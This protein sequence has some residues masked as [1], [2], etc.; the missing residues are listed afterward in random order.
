CHAAEQSMRQ[1]NVSIRE[2]E[3]VINTVLSNLNGVTAALVQS[4]ELLKNES[5]GIKSEVGEALV[6]LQ[7]QDRVSQIMTHVKDNIELLPDFFAKNHQQFEQV[8][9]LQ[10]LEADS[11]L[12]DLEKTYAM[13]EERSMHRGGTAVTVTAPSDEI[14]FF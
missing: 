14:T 2:S 9:A 13:A 7:F 11:L 6:Q 5:I 1:E 12:A 4:S 8:Q 3:N 10:P